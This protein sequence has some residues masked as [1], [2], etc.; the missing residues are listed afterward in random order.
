MMMPPSIQHFQEQD[1]IVDK[2]VATA[3]DGV[4]VLDTDTDQSY[5]EDFGCLRKAEH[6]QDEGMLLI[7]SQY[8]Y[9][10]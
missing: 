1:G 5:I 6:L 9:Q 7:P 10:H 3:C 2:E 4:L 8:Y